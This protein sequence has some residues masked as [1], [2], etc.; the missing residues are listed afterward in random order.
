MS[1]G[2]WQ[3]T[4]T[5]EEMFHQVSP[6][7]K[8]SSSE[9]CKTESEG[10]STRVLLNFIFNYFKVDERYN[11]VVNN[12]S[13]TVL[14]LGPKALYPPKL[15]MCFLKH[16]VY[17]KCKISTRNI[18]TIQ[19]FRWNVFTVTYFTRKVSFKGNMNCWRGISMLGELLRQWRCLLGLYIQRRLGKK[20]FFHRKHLPGRK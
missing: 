16:H 20:Q 14:I 11:V 8:M 15:E 5:Q 13:D 18:L 2:F 7:S 10:N 3:L 19:W 12:N 17:F 4:M 1:T 9:M 6:D